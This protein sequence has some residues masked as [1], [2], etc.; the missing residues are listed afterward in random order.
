MN[1]NNDNVSNEVLTDRM[2][3]FYF[4]HSLRP[5][6]VLT[7]VLETYRDLGVVLF[8]WSINRPTYWKKEENMKKVDGV[9]IRTITYTEKKGD[10]FSKKTGRNLA[11][12]MLRDNPVEL[13]LDPLRTSLETVLEHLNGWNLNFP[14]DVKN[15]A[16]ES[17]I[18]YFI[19]K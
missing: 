8:G 16:R 4:K 18:R 2:E 7:V 5:Q 3:V 9:R 17:A 1:Y 15:I 14:N 11:I 19:N 6:Q 12:K 13:S 10:Q